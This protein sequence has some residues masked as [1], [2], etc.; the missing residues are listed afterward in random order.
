MSTDDRAYPARPILAV[1]AGIVRDGRILLVRRAQ[2]PMQGVFTFPGGVVEAGETLHEAVTREVME[3]T[4]ITI[5]PLALAGYRDVVIRDKEGKISR[6]F[7]V[8]PFAARWVGGE[9]TPNAELA[10]GRWFGP[11]EFQ[12]LPTTDGLPEIVAAVLRQIETA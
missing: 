2:R 12:G 3:E 8:L 1:S 9:F 11:Y 6:H 4:G 7:V 10:E 5:A